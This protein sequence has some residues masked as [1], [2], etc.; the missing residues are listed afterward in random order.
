MPASNKVTTADE[1]IALIRSGDTFATSGFVGNGTP[2]ALLEAL[3]RGFHATGNT[4]AVI[5]QNAQFDFYD[6]GGLDLACLGMAQCDAAGNV[7]VSRYA[8]CFSGCGGF[9]NIS[10]NARRVCFLGTFTA[11]GLE[12][13]VGDGRLRIRSEARSSKFVKA[14]EQITF[15][16]AQAA[17][18]G[19][20]VLYITERCVFALAPDGLMLQE[21]APGIDLERDI[22]AKMEFVPLMAKSLRTMDPRLFRAEPMGLKESLLGRPLSERVVYDPER[23]ILFINFEGLALKNER[24]LT[25]LRSAVENCCAPLGRRVKAVVNY[26]GFSV[27]SHLIDSYA[28][29]VRDLCDRFYTEVTRYATSAFLRLKL[30]GTFAAHQVAPHLFETREEALRF[31]AS[32]SPR[33]EP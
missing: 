12:V 22:L 16:G 32:K 6:G 21:V 19:Q 15:S 29:V 11:G 28:E 27:P 14:V 26:D 7:N 30:G 8:H 9:I 25:A 31:L 5:D 20:R 2:D 10:Q 23:E 13:E 1:A 17:K 3:A 24:D 33:T 4:E 18:S